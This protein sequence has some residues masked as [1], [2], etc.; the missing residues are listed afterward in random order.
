MSRKL[1]DASRSRRVPRPGAVPS[2]AGGSVDNQ[3]ALSNGDYTVAVACAHDDVELEIF[4]PREFSWTTH[5][6]G[7]AALWAAFRHNS[8]TVS[9]RRS[10]VTNYLAQGDV[11]VVF[12]REEG[13]VRQTGEAYDVDIVHRFTFREGRLASLRI[14]AARAARRLR[15]CGELSGAARS[16]KTA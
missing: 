9:G 4:A 6:R 8:G 11:V 7:R 14:I 5:A 15:S 12:G 16:R 2:A 13:R 1:H 10:R 3:I